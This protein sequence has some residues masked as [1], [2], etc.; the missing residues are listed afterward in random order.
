[1]PDMIEVTT[2]CGCQE[3][4]RELVRKLVDERLAACAQISGPIESVYRWE[5][6]VRMDQEWRCTIKTLSALADRLIEFI[7]AHHPYDVPEILVVNVAKSSASYESW[8]RTEV[9]S[10]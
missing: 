10:P 3:T 6:E 7:S 9:R 2:T 1:M 8:V 5:G 4:A